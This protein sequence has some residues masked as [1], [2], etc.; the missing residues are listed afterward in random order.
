MNI[1]GAINGWLVPV[2]KKGQFTSGFLAHLLEHCTTSQRSW[3]RILFDPPV[4]IFQVS[5]R[6][7]CLNHF[8]RELVHCSFRIMNGFCGYHRQKAA[9]EVLCEFVKPTVNP[10]D[11]GKNKIIHYHMMTF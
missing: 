9:L 7:D 11:I 1:T 3:V 4:R 10:R 2:F 5:T 6:D 8:F